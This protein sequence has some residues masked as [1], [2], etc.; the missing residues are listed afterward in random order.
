M[1]SINNIPR[2]ALDDSCA[3]HGCGRTA[4]SVHRQ[5]A[6]CALDI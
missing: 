3:V 6:L 1:R 4:V 5:K 2:R